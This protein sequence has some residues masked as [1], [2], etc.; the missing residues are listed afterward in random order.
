VVEI[1]GNSSAG[2][3]FCRLKEGL[4]FEN[5]KLKINKNLITLDSCLRLYW[6]ELLRILRAVS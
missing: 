3:E 6:W 1:N 2:R 4:G 5:Y